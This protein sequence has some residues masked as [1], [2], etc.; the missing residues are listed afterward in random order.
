MT[1]HETGTFR[2]AD[3][4]AALE[5]GAA[6]GPGHREAAATAPRWA[7]TCTVFRIQPAGPPR[8]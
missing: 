5:P 2:T 6:P 7:A 4:K 8:S 3:Q 1:G